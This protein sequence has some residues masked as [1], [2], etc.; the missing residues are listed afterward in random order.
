MKNNSMAGIL[1][2]TDLDG[3]LVTDKGVIPA[4]NMEA[5]KRFIDKGGLFT[6]ATGRSVLGTERFASKVPLNA[7]CVVY[8]GGGIYDF[9][10]KTLLWSHYLPGIFM[11]LVDA[12]KK[13]FPDVG[14]EV[15]AGG[16][17]Y[18][19]N[20][21]EYTKAHISLLGIDGADS[22]G[23]QD[24]PRSNKVLFCG[25]A[26]R[27]MEVSAC[28]EGMPHDGCEFVFSGPTYFEILPAGITK[29]AAVKILGGMLGVAPER[30]M[31]IGDYYN[32]IEMLKEAAVSAVPDGVPAEVRAAA[33]LVVGPCEG[34][35]VAD[36][37][38]H[39]EARFG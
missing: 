3:T 36:F 19:V 13:Q 18:Y 39:L 22:A 34:G 2:V 26:G 33:D 14:I 31:S 23:E 9:R 25:D 24:L 38:E 28:L 35:A 30:V 29:A 20:R 32:D 1:L 21:N 6:F 12:V 27:L 16:G 37:I 11:E 8:N 15:Y 4:R 7:P 5:I 10:T 17:V